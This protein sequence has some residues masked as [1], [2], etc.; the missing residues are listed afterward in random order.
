[1]R[2]II[3][4]LTPDNER[5]HLVRKETGHYY[6][7]ITRVVL[8]ASDSAAKTGIYLI[9]GILIA[10]IPGS[11][12]GGENNLKAFSKAV[13][14]ISGQH[15]VFIKFPTGKEDAIFIRSLKFVK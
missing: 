15:D 12:T 9:N 2:L 5:A 4:R 14:N 13:K 3:S 7:A 8:D 1:M 6:T 11:S 10:T